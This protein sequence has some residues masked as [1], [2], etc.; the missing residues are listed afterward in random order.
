ME[1]TSEVNTQHRWNHYCHAK[2]P[3][4]GKKC[5]LYAPHEG[6]HMPIPGTQA[7]RWFD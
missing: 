1:G 2:N 7:D 3:E 6:G 4:N 5:R